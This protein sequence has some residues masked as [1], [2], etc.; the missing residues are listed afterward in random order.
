MENGRWRIHSVKG[1]VWKRRVRG[2]RGT[3]AGSREGTRV[4][5]KKSE[6]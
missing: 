3:V 5:P 2:E 4:L 6:G 1:G